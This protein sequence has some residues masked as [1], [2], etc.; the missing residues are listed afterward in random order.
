MDHT[1]PATP[2]DFLSLILT[3]RMASRVQPA[4]VKAE[5]QGD[6]RVVGSAQGTR[7]EATCT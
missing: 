6:G 5:A 7:F 2:T 3:L 4:E 1:L